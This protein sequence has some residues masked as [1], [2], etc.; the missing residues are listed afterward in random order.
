MGAQPYSQR[1]LLLLDNGHEK[2]S[3]SYNMHMV[4]TEQMQ[5]DVAPLFLCGALLVALL[6]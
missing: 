5:L 6:W 3:H 2:E 1:E 4:K